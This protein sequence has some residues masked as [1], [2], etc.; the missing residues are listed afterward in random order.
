MTQQDLQNWLETEPF[1]PFR[2]HLTD[3][4]SIAISNPDMIKVGFSEAVVITKFGRIVKGRKLA[5]R[6]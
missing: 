2:L 3:G 1:R 4:T 6:L 5:E